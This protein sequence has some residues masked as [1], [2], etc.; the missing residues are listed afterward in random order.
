MRGRF[1]RRTLIT[2]IAA[3]TFT[4]A[5]GACDWS[6]YVPPGGL[7]DPTTTT[8][9]SV[10]PPGSPIVGS[11]PSAKAFLELPG[12]TVPESSLIAFSTLPGAKTH[13]TTADNGHSLSFSNCLITQQIIID[14]LSTV[15]L[16]FTNCKIL[17]NVSDLSYG[18]IGK[19]GTLNF[20]HCLIDGS[21]EPDQDWPLILEGPAATVKFSEFVHNTD[22]A[23]LDTAVDFEW[24]YIHD[25]KTVTTSGA[26]HSDGVEV[27][28]GGNSTIAHNVIS[29]GDAEGGTGNVN[30]TNDFGRI[31]NIVIDDNVFMPGG[32]ASVYVRSDGACKCGAIKN[33]Q[34]TNN[35]W[36]ASTT[37]K[38]GGFYLAWSINNS[39]SITGW[40]GNTL[41]RADGVTVV[42]V[43]ST[44]AQP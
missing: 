40:S 15:T 16:T 28:F 35:R 26:G 22:N 2:L 23:R 30:V 20:I 5:L 3:A 6:V 10:L 4:V 41:T 38:W 12:L 14:P 9:T 21:A 13:Y 17:V 37:Y 24:N 8:S 36:Y 39:T 19:G 44:Q 29:L 42:T 25:F 1:G 43:D 33:V 7:S 34:V 27:Y 11:G 32:S 18:M 31:A